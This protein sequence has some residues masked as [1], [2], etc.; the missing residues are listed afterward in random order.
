MIHTRL[1]GK[2]LATVD[3]LELAGAIIDGL[4]DREIQQIG[5][6]AAARDG[7][8]RLE[9]TQVLRRWHEAKL[10]ALRAKLNKRWEE[11]LPLADSLPAEQRQPVVEEMLALSKA[12]GLLG[13][14]GD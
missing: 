12:M 6:G 1:K 10:G 7:G 8:P 2:D 4:H 3:P 9:L 5:Y 14:E 11:L 13:G